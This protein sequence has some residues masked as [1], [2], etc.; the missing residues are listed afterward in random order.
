MTVLANKS[1]QPTPGSALSSAFA[2]HVIGPAWLS[3]SRW[4]AAM[5]L[6]GPLVTA[7]EGVPAFRQTLTTLRQL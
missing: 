7:I 1:L 5:A 6:S 4:A 2:D 3:S